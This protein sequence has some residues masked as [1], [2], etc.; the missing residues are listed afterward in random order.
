MYARVVNKYR[1]ILLFSGWAKVLFLTASGC[2][3]MHFKHNFV[4]LLGLTLLLY[5]RSSVKSSMFTIVLDLK[6]IVILV[7]FSRVKLFEIFS[8][9]F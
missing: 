8:N 9:M 3:L 6:L 7:W 4:S 5:S 1:R 2:V